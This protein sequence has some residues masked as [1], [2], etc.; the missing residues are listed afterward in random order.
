MREGVEARSPRTLG[1]VQNLGMLYYG[2]GEVEEAE[3]MLKR[4]L[5]G[6]KKVL[7]PDHP[8]TLLVLRNLELLYSKRADFGKAKTLPKRENMGYG[9]APEV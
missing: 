8:N 2:R 3:K 9:K 4:A 7:E 6:F 5:A 1:I